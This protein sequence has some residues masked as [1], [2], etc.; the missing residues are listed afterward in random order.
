MIVEYR[1][2]VEGLKN[3]YSKLLTLGG[4]IDIPEVGIM[5]IEYDNSVRDKVIDSYMWKTGKL[6]EWLNIQQTILNIFM[7]YERRILDRLDNWWWYSTCNI[8]GYTKL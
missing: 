8:S 2:S 4:T 6:K 3:I 1:P 5:T 7:G